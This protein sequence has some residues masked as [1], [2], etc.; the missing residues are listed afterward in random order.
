MKTYKYLL[1]LKRILNSIFIKIIPKKTRIYTVGKEKQYRSLKK[2]IDEATKYMGSIIYV[3]DGIYDLYEEFGSEYFDAINKYSSNRMGIILKN[4]IHI[5]FSNNSKVIFN[6]KGN[7]EYVKTKF[8][9]FNAGDFGFTLEN[10]N[11]E[12]SNCR[13]CVHDEM[14][15]SLFSY[16]NKY[17][18]CEM[19]MDNSNNTDW[20]S[21]QC[22]GGG[23][24][25]KGKI[26]VIDSKFSTITKID[27]P[28]VSWH[29]RGG[30]MHSVSKISISNCKFGEKN[31]FRLNSYGKF[32]DI[33]TATLSYNIFGAPV[34]N[35]KTTNDSYKNTEIIEFNNKYNVS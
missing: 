15:A 7:N 26:F 8:S 4:K 21:Y 18:N 24:G 16:E 33:T 9:P 32:K 22:I 11:I 30:R 2:C 25:L 19:K 29:N 20:N 13:Y 35:S 28:A 34:I 3:H 31:T 23:L 14:H 6:Y 27:Y 5:I 12:C 17:I 10:L 1:Y